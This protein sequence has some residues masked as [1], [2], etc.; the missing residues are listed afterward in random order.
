[1][2]GLRLDNWDITNRTGYH[3][4][5]SVFTDLCIA[6]AFGENAIRETCQSAFDAFKDGDQ[7]CIVELDMA[8]ASRR[9]ARK[10][11][12]GKY[13]ELYSELINTL[14]E[15]CRKHLSNDDLAL[16]SEYFG[17]SNKEKN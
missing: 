3:P 14:S 8:L 2:C 7:S 6:E 13:V 11:K 1:M 5:T 9:N 12:D 17:G 15:W 4:K 10:A 16:F